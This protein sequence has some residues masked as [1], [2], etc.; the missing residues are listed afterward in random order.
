MT[1]LL[2]LLCFGC[3]LAGMEMLVHSSM[4]THIWGFLEPAVLVLDAHELPA[5]SASAQRQ[6]DSA[7]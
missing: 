3:D 7:R 2:A 5:G 6:D 4:L 1:V